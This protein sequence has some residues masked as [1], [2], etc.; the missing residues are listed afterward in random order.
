MHNKP[1][2]QYARADNMITIKEMNRRFDILANEMCA[3]QRTMIKASLTAAK[4]IHISVAHGLKLKAMGVDMST[5]SK[6]LNAMLQAIHE[7]TILEDEIHNGI[8]PRERTRI[9]ADYHQQSQAKV[10]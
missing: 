1:N 6:E 3:L 9:D 10:H 2:Q 8:A 5:R 4:M 7:M